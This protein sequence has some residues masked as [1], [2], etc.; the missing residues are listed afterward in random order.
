[1]FFHILLLI[2]N[3][4]NVFAIAGAFKRVNANLVILNV[5]FS[6]QSVFNCIFC[7]IL[8]CYLELDVFYVSVELKYY[9]L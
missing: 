4:F 3:N 2:F 5:I 1:M 6:V 7:G 9:I 8:L